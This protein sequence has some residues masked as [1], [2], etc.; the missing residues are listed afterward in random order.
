MADIPKKIFNSTITDQAYFDKYSIQLGKSVNRLLDKAQQDIVAALAKNDPT[1]QTMT[2]WKQ[3]R[4]TQLNKDID[5]IVTSTYKQV[6]DMSNKALIRAGG[7]QA[8]TAVASINKAVGADIFGVTLEP[9]TIKAIIGNTMIGGKTIGEWW[10][11]QSA[12]TKSKLSAAM[13][14]G[15]QALQIGMV[16]GESIGQL[17]A[18]I[19]G[20]ATTPGVMSL[21]KR[22]ATALAR[23]SVMQVSGAVRQELYKA[24]ADVLKGFQ[25][26]STLDNRTTPQC[27]MMDGKEYDM[28]M[29][30]IGHSIPFP[31]CPAHWNCRST[32]IPVTRSWAELKGPDSPLTEKQVAKLDNIPVGMRASMGGPV[33]ADVTYQDWLLD[34]DV[35]VQK[36]ILGPGRYKLWSENKLDVGDLVT[37]TG[38]SL[39]I[40]E[41]EKKFGVMYKLTPEIPAEVMSSTAAVMTSDWIPVK[42]I[43]EATK[44]FKEQFRIDGITA[45]PKQLDVFNI[46]GDA[47]TNIKKLPRFVNKQLPYLQ[48]FELLDKTQTITEAGRKVTAFYRPDVKYISIGAKG[49][50]LNNT[51]KFG[52]YSVGE[53]IASITRHEY[54]HFLWNE[55]LT[56]IERKRFEKIY[57]NNSTVWVKQNISEYASTSLKEGFAESFSAYTSPLYK[58]GMLPKEI[59]AYFDDIFGKAK[60]TKA[61]NYA[62]DTS[63]MPLSR[64]ALWSDL[65]DKEYR[66]IL[67]RKAEKGNAIEIVP[68]IEKLNEFA[69]NKVF[70]STE[71]ET[72]YFGLDGKKFASLKKGDTFDSLGTRST[73]LTLERSKQ[74]AGDTGTIFQLEIPKGVV[75]VKA[76]VLGIEERMLLPGSKFEVIGK[77]GGVVRLR[78]IDDGSSYVKELYSFQNKLDE[79]AKVI[80]SE[81]K[82]TLYKIS[83]KVA[84]AKESHLPAT[85]AV[86]KIATENQ[87]LAALKV[88]GIETVDNAPFDI[89]RGKDYIELKTI[90][91]ASNDKITMHPESLAR[92][93]KS[94]ENVN[95]ARAHTLVIDERTGKVYYS[96]GLGSF[97]LSTMT[98]IGTKNNFGPNLLRVLKGQKPIL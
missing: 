85:R 55:D 69:T 7:L 93:L 28:N 19:R 75:S 91:R 22:E 31:G 89:I 94:I 68:Q 56:N 20:S 80:K 61:I 8:K 62:V 74:Y 25:W 24:N 84:K 35:L 67:I 81:P 12:S 13:K 34:Q 48:E 77:T 73:S 87:T 38:H 83:E 11:N 66:D 95:G 10:D 17:V 2:K 96:I 42:T 63:G 15:T 64:G 6:K 58:Q 90:V 50:G 43:D 3:A 52:G 18:Q 47:L 49:K 16:Q 41:L 78:L 33:P 92:K 88:G 36:D 97:R 57:L 65:K 27:R 23:T 5:S 21:T 51:L 26:V 39:T 53:D 29:N 1:S 54:G 82:E 30:P 76:N 86:Q 37:D 98:E 46:S 70:L 72:V 45:V 71:K 60:V 32:I 44:I 59:E 40:D 79:L 4:L 14:A 9:A